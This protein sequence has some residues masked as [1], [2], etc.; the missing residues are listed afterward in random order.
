L[1][2]VKDARAFLDNELGNEQAFHSDDRDGDLQKLGREM[3]DP[4]HAFSR[5]T[6]ALVIS[7]RA[8]WCPRKPD[9]FASADSL[10]RM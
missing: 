9:P 4:F 10:G 1:A 3:K 8:V 2:R 5:V 6:R 7:A